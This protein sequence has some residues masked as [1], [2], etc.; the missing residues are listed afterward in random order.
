M[1]VSHLL[2]AEKLFASNLPHFTVE[3]TESL[4]QA[5]GQRC[6]QS[7]LAETHWAKLYNLRKHNKEKPTTLLYQS[8]PFNAKGLS[9]DAENCSI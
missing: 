6:G 8:Q 9:G 5:M 2:L 3:N 1:D 4:L 7:L